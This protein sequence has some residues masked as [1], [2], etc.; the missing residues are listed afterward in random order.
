MNLIFIGDVVGKGGREAIRKLVPELRREFNCQF[1]VVNAE[2]SAAGSGL[3]AGC[4][5]ELLEAADVLTTGDHVWDQ[6]GF[7]ADIG[8]F[9][10]ILR[11]A[12]LRKGQPGRGWGIYRN[13]A[14]GDLAVINL[15]GKVFMRDSAYDPFETIDTILLEMLPK[16]IKTI[17]VDF[18]AEAT[19]EK[20]AM[21]YFLDGRVTALLGTHT[22]VPTAD[23]LVLPGGTARQTDVGMTGAATSV[24]GRDV[25]DVLYKFKTGMPNRLAVVEK[26]IMRV[27]GTV[28]G[29]DPATGHADAIHPFSRE[30]E[31][32]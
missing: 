24:L 29:Y 14:G 7:D 13:P 12:N 6:R 26:G 22:H 2:N 28:V 27:D 5:R 15:V 3:T 10:R 4:A 32:N 9:D 1:V 21:G 18:H 19:S 17:L 25:N 23:A 11:P 20:L 31:I 16:S 8:R 30:I